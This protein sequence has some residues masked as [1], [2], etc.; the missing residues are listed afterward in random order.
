MAGSSQSGRSGVLPV[1]NL[2]VDDTLHRKSS[3]AAG[4]MDEKEAQLEVL[5][6]VALRCLP[7][8]KAFAIV[9]KFL[10]HQVTLS[11]GHFEKH[12]SD[13]AET[14]FQRLSPNALSNNLFSKDHF[15]QVV[16]Q[17]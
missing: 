1:L 10:Q 16:F 13:L 3:G 11:A 7:D 8:L 9:K 2:L 6:S 14:V 4:A 5:L 12:V 15:I 17:V